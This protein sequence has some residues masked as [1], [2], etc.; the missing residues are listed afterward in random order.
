MLEF[1]GLGQLLRCEYVVV[2]VMIFGLL[3]TTEDRLALE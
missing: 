2:V 1:A 3:L